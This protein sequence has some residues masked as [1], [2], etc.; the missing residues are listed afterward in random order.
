ML[1]H[2]RKT[3]QPVRFGYGRRTGSNQPDATLAPEDNLARQPVVSFAGQVGPIPL[4]VTGK[5][6]DGT[7]PDYTRVVPAELVRVVRCER[8]AL[9]DALAGLMPLHAGRTRAVKIEA[10]PGGLR[11]SLDCPDIGK[12]SIVISAEHGCEPGLLCGFN[13]QY[14]LDCLKA[15][16]GEEVEFGWAIIGPDNPV[17]IRDPADT[18]FKA[19]L[20][21]MRV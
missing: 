20:M 5:L 6:I 15:L 2:F 9:L 13:A 17:V 16:R 7:Y 12:A 1:S 19:V 10:E 4:T 3:Q 14:L 8:S 11:V 18:A 21:P